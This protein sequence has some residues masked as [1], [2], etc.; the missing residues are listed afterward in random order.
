MGEATVPAI[1]FSNAVKEIFRT[2]MGFEVNEVKV[3]SDGCENVQEQVTG[4]LTVTGDLNMMI[5]LSMSKKT[6]FAIMVYMLGIQLTELK[7]EDVYDGIG[8]TVNMITGHMRT[9]ASGMGIRLKALSPFIVAGDN[10]MLVYK[11]K[12]ESLVKRFRMG[13]LDF[14]LKV[15]SYKVS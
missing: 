1:Y 5:S 7:E 8:E 15:M 3:A 14:L 4:F 11:N 2:M 13:N 12:V 10:Y 6:A 9:Q